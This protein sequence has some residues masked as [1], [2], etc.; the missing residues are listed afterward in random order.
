MTLSG[1]QLNVPNGNSLCP[2]FVLSR[3]TGNPAVQLLNGYTRWSVGPLRSQKPKL[4]G[5]TPGSGDPDQVL[6][7]DELARAQVELD[8]KRA[9]RGRLHLDVAALAV[10]EAHLVA[11][12][13]DRGICQQ[14]SW[15][16]TKVTG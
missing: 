12:L 11:S 13:M 1:V 16:S 5:H 2:F 10:E 14:A 8:V 6:Q 9:V 7:D 4:D 15:L 3:N